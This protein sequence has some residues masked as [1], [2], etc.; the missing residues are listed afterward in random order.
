MFKTLFKDK[1]KI[2][3]E[4]DAKIAKKES[5]LTSICNTIVAK[6]TDVAKLETGIAELTKKLKEAKYEQVRDFNAS[7][8]WDAMQ[9]FSIE[10][11]I[12]TTHE[13]PVTCIGY[14]AENKVKEWILFVNKEIHDALVE[15]FKEY[16]RKKA[17]L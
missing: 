12:S 14:K 6:E 5:V 13:V 7:V 1:N 2:L 8:D 9:A 16:V 15:E 10:R 3:E 11:V 4:L 17:E